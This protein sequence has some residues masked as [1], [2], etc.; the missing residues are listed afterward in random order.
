[1][2]AVHL[3]IFFLAC[4]FIALS[5]AFII[6]LIGKTGVRDS[7]IMTSPKLV[8]GLFSCDFCLSFWISLAMAAVMAFFTWDPCYLL[9]PVLTTPITR[10]LI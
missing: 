3:I 10:L 2:P 1:M 8:S 6:L 5:S 7:I 9:A 4:A